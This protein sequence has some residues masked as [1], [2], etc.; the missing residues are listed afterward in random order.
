MFD[1]NMI[2]YIIWFNNFRFHNFRAL[3]LNFRYPKYINKVIKLLETQWNFK[4]TKSSTL[5]DEKKNE[6]RKIY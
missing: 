5:L 4:K 3:I 2:V 6:K 1:T